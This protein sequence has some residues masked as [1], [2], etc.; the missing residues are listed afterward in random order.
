MSLKRAV[1]A[2]AILLLAVPAVANAGG[3]TDNP[4]TDGQIINGSKLVTA[5]GGSDTPGAISVRF[6]DNPVAMFYQSDNGVDA[7]QSSR[8]LRD[9]RGRY[10]LFVRRNRV[11]ADQ[12]SGRHRGRQ[13]RLAVEC[14]ERLHHR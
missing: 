13:P 4:G 2:A 8:H 14:H 6:A 1:I 7:S 9:S 11:H 3:G 10:R 12:R 5:V